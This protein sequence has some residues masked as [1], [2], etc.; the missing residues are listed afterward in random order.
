MT[1]KTVKTEKSAKKAPEVTPEKE[2]SF[3]CKFCGETKPIVELVIM[4]QFF[5]PISSCKT[6]AK[7]TRNAP[8]V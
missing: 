2:I 4:S 3:T 1:D 7:A 8:G 5:P 6:C